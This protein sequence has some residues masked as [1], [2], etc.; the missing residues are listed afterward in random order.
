MAQWVKD[1]VLL[2][3]I[4]SLVY[5][6]PCAMSVAGKG[7]QRRKSVTEISYLNQLLKNLCRGSNSHASSLMH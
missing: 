1:L 4:Q 5:E 2:A 7:E 3:R 6:L